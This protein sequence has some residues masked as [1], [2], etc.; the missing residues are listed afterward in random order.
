MLSIYCGAI[1]FTIEVVVN[2][3]F[4]VREAQVGAGVEPP[5]QQGMTES[6]NPHQGRPAGASRK[7][8]VGKFTVLK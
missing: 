4:V 2:L 1:L 8:I 6:V 5:P 7:S 3:L